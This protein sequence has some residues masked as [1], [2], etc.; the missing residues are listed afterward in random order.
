M[1]FYNSKK[2]YRTIFSDYF[3][4]SKN[5][6]KY[7]SK[8]LCMYNNMV[9]LRLDLYI[10]DLFKYIIHGDSNF[11]K[12]VTAEDVIDFSKNGTELIHNHIIS[13]F[14]NCTFYTYTCRFVKFFLYK[15]R[16]KSAYYDELMSYINVKC[17]YKKFVFPS[18]D[19]KNIYNQCIRLIPSYTSDLLY[20]FFRD[21]IPISLS[22]Y[23]GFHNYFGRS[24]SVDKLI[25]SQRDNRFEV[26]NNNIAKP[27]DNFIK[28]K[29]FIG[30]KKFTTMKNSVTSLEYM[31]DMYN[32]PLSFSSDIIKHITI[33][34]RFNISIFEFEFIKYMQHIRIVFARTNN[35]KKIAE[36][37]SS[38]LSIVDKYNSYVCEKLKNHTDIYI[39]NKYYNCE[40]YDYFID[41]TR[42][43]HIILTLFLENIFKQN[44]NL[45]KRPRNYIP[46]TERKKNIFEILKTYKKTIY[47]MILNQKLDYKNRTR[48]QNIQKKIKKINNEL[49]LSYY[50][51]LNTSSFIYMYKNICRLTP[52]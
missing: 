22:Y 41:R 17:Y 28:S 5:F 30:S 44:R 29:F 2:F 26:I 10:I 38:G 14:K 25:G 12:L 37:V 7:S 23:Y 15:T 13:K 42:S 34:P 21:L 1:H 4:L 19:F 6:H 40:K 47:D 51:Y 18:Y 32:I 50:R 8:Q 49:Y 36:F 9:M 39:S 31:K 35:F 46:Y 45:F 24:S 3:I 48:I 20:M 52:Y 27:N 33:N 11:I 16:S 43:I